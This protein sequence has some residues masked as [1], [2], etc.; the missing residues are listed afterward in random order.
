MRQ[1]ILEEEVFLVDSEAFGD[2]EEH[3]YNVRCFDGYG[4]GKSND[5]IKQPKIVRLEYPKLKDVLADEKK[6]L[7]VTNYCGLWEMEDRINFADIMFTF[8]KV[9]KKID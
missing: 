4:I 2:D 1:Y 7:E 8:G 3:C 6:L 9:T 5:T